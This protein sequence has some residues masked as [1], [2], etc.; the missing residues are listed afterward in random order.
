MCR[1][2]ILTGRRSA[3]FQ[4]RILKSGT[5]PSDA[6]DG[7]YIDGNQVFTKTLNPVLHSPFHK[8]PALF[9]TIL[10]LSALP[11]HA[12]SRKWLYKKAKAE[13]ALVLY[14][15]GPTAPWEAV[16]KKFSTR[17]PGVHVKIA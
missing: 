17:Y 16:A 10:I 3:R 15:G 6:A 9:L 2:I 11:A 4:P 7:R 8:P 14:A 13:G 12:Q 5:C 1:S